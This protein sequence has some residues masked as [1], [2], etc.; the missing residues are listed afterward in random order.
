MKLD[1]GIMQVVGCNELQARLAGTM[2]LSTTLQ[3]NS[4]RLHQR[5]LLPINCVLLYGPAG[6]LVFMGSGLHSQGNPWEHAFS[7]LLE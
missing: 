2:P 1:A 7:N 4:N 3:N 5:Q 6:F